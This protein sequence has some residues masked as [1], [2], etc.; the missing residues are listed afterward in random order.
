MMDTLYSQLAALEARAYR[1]SG[2]S[3]SHAT[4]IRAFGEGLRAAQS[5]QVFGTVFGTVFGSQNGSG[6]SSFTPGTYRLR[7]VDCGGNPISGASIVAKVGSEGLGDFVTIGAT[8]SDGYFSYYADSSATALYAA[9]AVSTYGE[10]PA[11]GPIVGYTFTLPLVPTAPYF[12]LCG[13]LMQPDTIEDC[14]GTAT[15]TASGT[16]WTATTTMTGA[17]KLVN[18]GAAF[19]PAYD[20]SLNADL[21]W[22]LFMSNAG[23]PV[24][25]IDLDGAIDQSV[26]F[27]PLVPLADSWQG[28]TDP[29]NRIGTYY[30]FFTGYGCKGTLSCA[31][32]PPEFNVTGSANGTVS[33]GPPYNVFVPHQNALNGTPLWTPQAGTNA[34]G[35]HGTWAHR[36]VDAT[37]LTIAKIKFKDYPPP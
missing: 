1:A 17:F 37:P 2:V 34:F 12:C 33:I 26:L 31:S 7:A 30:K 8:D 35:T 20:G 21:V 15:W 32:T 4:R 6:D 13:R 16:S 19:A 27:D 24:V 10:S 25:S 3:D 14:Y 23:T 36:L 29:S 28:F 11:V 5:R 22:T 9:K 18:S